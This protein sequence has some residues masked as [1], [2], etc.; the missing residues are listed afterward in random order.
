LQFAFITVGG[1]AAPVGGVKTV[2]VETVGVETVGVETVGGPEVGF[3]DVRVVLELCEDFVPVEGVPHPATT[4][5]RITAD[6]ETIAVT[7]LSDQPSTGRLGGCGD[8]VTL[9]RLSSRAPAVIGQT[10][11]S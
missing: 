7:P 2:G 8:S 5:A 3:V 10:A 6:V 9:V 1:G 11:S 4:A